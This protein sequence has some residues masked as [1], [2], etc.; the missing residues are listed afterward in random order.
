M[1]RPLYRPLFFDELVDFSPR[2]APRF[3]DT[4]T[5]TLLDE[6]GLRLKRLTKM[7]EIIGSAKEY[8]KLEID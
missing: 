3:G 4:T 7:L 1:H 5:T 6:T 2:I 8:G